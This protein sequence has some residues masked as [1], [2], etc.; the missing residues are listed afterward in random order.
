M[1][2]AFQKVWV[3]KNLFSDGVSFKEYVRIVKIYMVNFD[4]TIF[5]RLKIMR[6]LYINC[7]F[8]KIIPFLINFFSKFSTILKKMFFTK[9]EHHKPAIT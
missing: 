8:I 6:F 5:N 7:K 3:V 1:K 9:S 4:V 2:M